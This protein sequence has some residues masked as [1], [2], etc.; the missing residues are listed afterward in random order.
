MQNRYDEIA[1]D[2]STVKFIESKK[3]FQIIEN[4]F[5]ALIQ[6]GKL[7]IPIKE[8]FGGTKLEI[9]FDHWD[10][11]LN[12]KTIED[13]SLEK[14]DLEFDDSKKTWFLTEDK[15]QKILDYYNY[16]KIIMPIIIYKNNI[17]YDQDRE[18]FHNYFKS[19][20]NLCLKDFLY[21]YID[22]PYPFEPND[23]LKKKTQN[24]NEPY[25]VI[26]KI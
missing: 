25:I 2:Y 23:Y 20:I 13:F 6:N 22:E 7:F 3:Y 26:R 17:K 8:S 9:Y 15:L 12:K 14:N 24:Y 4:L 21:E 11:N 16:D 18:K 19:G 10:F 1:F 5:N